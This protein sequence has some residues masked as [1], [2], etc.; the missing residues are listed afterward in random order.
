MA[1]I[2]AVNTHNL[3][4]IDATGLKDT[5]FGFGLFNP[6][7][8]EPPIAIYTTED[9]HHDSTD[10]KQ[11]FEDVIEFNTPEYFRDIIPGI[12]PPKGS[13]Y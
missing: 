13:G 5:K 7:V 3:R 11:D 1:L 9:R 4:D 6:E 8:L 2:N 10:C 12:Y